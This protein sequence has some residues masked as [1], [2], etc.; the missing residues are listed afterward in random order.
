MK[1]ALLFLLLIPFSVGCTLGNSR[2][3]DLTANSEKEEAGKLLNMYPWAGKARVYMVGDYRIITPA[4]NPGPTLQVQGQDGP[5][6]LV[7]SHPPGLPAL[8]KD[9]GQVMTIFKHGRVF[10]MDEN[11]DLVVNETINDQLNSSPR[12][13]VS[14]FDGDGIYDRLSY[15][16][17]DNEGRAVVD[18]VDFTLNGQPDLKIVHEGEKS[19]SFAWLKDAWHR[20]DKHGKQPGVIIDGQW[21]PIF[22]SE[23]KWK[24]Q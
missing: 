14:D 9:G 5:F 21:K 8:S 20:I 22:I 11:G 23:G 7:D 13:C 1:K 15:T 4:E 24:F 17:F 3:V 12:I 16:A 18:I 19:T 10:I 2:V 6:I